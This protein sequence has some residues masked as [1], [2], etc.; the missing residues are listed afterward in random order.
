M[1]YSCLQNDEEM[2]RNTFISRFVRSSGGYEGIRRMCIA[3]MSLHEQKYEEYTNR[4][5]GLTFFGKHVKW[6]CHIYIQTMAIKVN[7]SHVF[8][9]SL[10][11]RQFVDVVDVGRIMNELH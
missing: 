2:R 5:K 8:A 6:E 4:T 10:N 3:V 11:I 1:Q 9:L 7:L